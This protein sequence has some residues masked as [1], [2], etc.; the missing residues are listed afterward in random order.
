MDNAG[1]LTF[2]FKRYQIQKVWRGE[3]PQAGRYREF[4]QADIDIVDAGELPAH[5][6]AELLFDVV[7]EKGETVQFGSVGGGGRYDG[8]VARFRGEAAPATGFSIG[9]SRETPM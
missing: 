2:P 5:Y 4:V 7:N 8:L 9:V 3:R 1:L 6:E